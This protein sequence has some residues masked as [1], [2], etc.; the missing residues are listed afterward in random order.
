MNARVLVTGAT[1]LIGRQAV[2]CLLNR[3]NE[4][5]AFSRSD[6]D[7]PRFHT[8]QVDLLDRAARLAAV[9]EANAT[10]L[11]HLAWHDHPRDRWS[12]PENRDWA[13]ATVQLVHEFSDLGGKRAL[14]AGSCAEYDWSYEQLKETTPLRPATVY[15]QAKADT[16]TQVIEMSRE[17]D[18]SLVWARLFFC[19]GPREPRGRLLGDLLYGLSAGQEIPCTDGLQE[20][21]YL[22]TEDIGEA[23]ALA[24]ESDVTGAMNIASGHATKVRDII[25]TT[26]ELMGRPELI[27]LGALARASDDPPRLVADV[28]QLENIG[29]KPK[30]DLGSGLAQCVD[31]LEKRISG[32]V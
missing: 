8:I 23:L 12:A 27:S 11:L 1:G 10:H 29:F 21:D 13:T 14:C 30:Y 25:Q 32:Q 6:V 31:E 2:N 28:A 5:I 3:G 15:G 7:D 16:G 9:R 19:Y 4:V 26:A 20:R 24:L 22:H 18:L 17:L